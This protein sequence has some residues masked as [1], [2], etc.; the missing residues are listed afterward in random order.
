MAQSKKRKII[1]SI[2][3]SIVLAALYA[4]IFGYSAQDGETSGSLSAYISM[5]C[6]EA[7][8]G[9]LNGKWTDAFVAELALYFEHPIRKLAHFT[10]Y[11]LLGGTIYIL[12]RQWMKRDWKLVGITIVWVLLSA[13]GDEL[14]QYFVPGRWSSPL[15]VMLDTCGGVFAVGCLVLC[16]KLHLRKKGGR[17]KEP[18]EN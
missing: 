12:L 5:L 8:N 7:V 11:A 3:C 1:I 10:E 17:R 14:H 2:L 13:M 18:G 9:L 16:E 6:V 15:D 4:M